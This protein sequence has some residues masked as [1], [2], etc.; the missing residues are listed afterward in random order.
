VG[1]ND[2]EDL[3][4]EE[5]ER[6]RELRA[7]FPGLRIVLVAPRAATFE[8]VEASTR[9]FFV[10]A[11]DPDSYRLGE[12]FDARI[13]HTGRAAACRLEVVRKEIDPRSGLALRIARIDPAGEDALRAILG[14]GQS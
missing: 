10:R 11:A 7:I 4:I 12:A 8:A 13:E 14:L 1:A 5:V 3:A 9:S 6:R 2:E